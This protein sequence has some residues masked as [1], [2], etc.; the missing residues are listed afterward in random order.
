MMCRF[1][2]INVMFVSGLDKSRRC[3]LLWAIWRGRIVSQYTVSLS[4]VSPTVLCRSLTISSFSFEWFHSVK[5][6]YG[7]SHIMTGVGRGAVVS[8]R[9]VD[10]SLC[11]ARLVPGQEESGWVQWQKL[12]GLLRDNGGSQAADNLP[13]PRLWCQRVFLHTG[14]CSKL[15]LYVG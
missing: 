10:C 6:C 11:W 1:L 8:P 9:L 2:S 4:S 3:S 14:G 12:G 5:T 15:N 7:C 13:T